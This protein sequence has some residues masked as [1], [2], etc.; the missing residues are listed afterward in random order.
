MLSKR[1]K[2]DSGSQGEKYAANLLRKKGYKLVARN[3]RSKFGEIDIVAIKDST[4]VFVEV[5][6]R[7][8]RKFGT[9]S[10]A[11]TPQKLRRIKKAAEYFSLIHPQYPQKLSIEVVSLEVEDKKV[12]EAK[13]LQAY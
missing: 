5:K 2:K 1:S 8:S 4:L 7:W 6:T 11:V 3:V 12:I 9:P 10:E 13:I